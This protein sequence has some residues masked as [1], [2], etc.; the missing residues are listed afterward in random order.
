MPVFPADNEY[1]EKYYD[2]KYEY[3]HVFLNEQAFN[4]IQKSKL[5]AEDEWRMVGVVQSRGWEHYMIFTPEP[6]VLLFRRPKNTNP[7]TG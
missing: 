7:A 3:R 6:W 1:S 2:D 4:K 5:L